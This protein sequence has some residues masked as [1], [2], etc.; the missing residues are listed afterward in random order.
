MTYAVPRCVHLYGVHKPCVPLAIL[1]DLPNPAQSTTL[2]R[3]LCIADS[4]VPAALSNLMEITSIHGFWSSLLG[5]LML[6]G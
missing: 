6:P 2:H 5:I 3:P 1:T 4:H